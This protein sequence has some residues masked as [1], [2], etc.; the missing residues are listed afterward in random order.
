GGRAGVPAAAF[1][2]LGLRAGDARRTAGR[3][4]RDRV[5]R[6]RRGAGAPLLRRAPAAAA[7]PLRAADARSRGPPRGGRLRP[8][9][10]RP[11][12]QR[13][14]PRRPAAEELRGLAP[15]PR[16]V[17][18]LRRTLPAGGGQLP[19]SARSARGGRDPA[20][21]GLAVRA[22]RRRLPGAVPTLPRAAA[23]AAPGAAGGAPGGVRGGVVAR[24]PGAAARRRPYRR[25]AVSGRRPPARGGAGG[26]AGR[27]ALPS[28]GTAAMTR[29]LSYAL[30]PL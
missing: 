30:S 3:V 23:G 17:L 6:A 10:H 15:R 2:A 4:R 8:G 11:G 9:D 1:P 19:R 7:G 28:P 25:A 24:D 26:F 21:G 22:A 5:R 20:A 29:R 18:R 16:A 13:H 27:L 12:V 14:L